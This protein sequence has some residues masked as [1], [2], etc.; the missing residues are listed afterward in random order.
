MYMRSLWSGAISFGLIHIPITLYSATKDRALDFDMLRKDDLC[1]IS[2]ARV[3]RTTGEEVPYDEIVKG[4]EYREGDYVLLD[5]EDF[6]RAAPEKSETIDIEEFVNEDEIDSMYYEKPYYLEPGKGAEK[7]YVLL[8]EALTQSKKVAVA[9]FVFRSRED[10]VVL[11]AHNDVLIL[12]QLRFH[13]QIRD[14]RELK[15]PKK[16]DV[17]RKEIEMAIKLVEQLEGKFNPKQFED[18]YTEELEKI[19]QAKAKGK[20]LKPVPNPA[21]DTNTTDLIE[22]LKA[23]LEGGK[24][25][26]AA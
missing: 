17:T 3:C 16:V 25:S 9:T 8:R 22:Q 26:A 14:Y 23:S 15:L 7:A 20:K 2:F 6:K 12:N 1:P 19:I 18:T 4:Y 13:E 24:R 11:K 5:K 10:L 21:K